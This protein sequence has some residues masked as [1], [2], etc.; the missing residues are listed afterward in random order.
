MRKGIEIKEIEWVKELE[1]VI[2]GNKI[3]L[4]IGESSGSE[5]SIYYYIIYWF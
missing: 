1:K 5:I 4:V 2:L 3:D